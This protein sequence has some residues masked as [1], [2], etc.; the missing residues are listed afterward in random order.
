[1]LGRFVQEQKD[2]TI[3]QPH[4][5]VVLVTWMNGEP[6]PH[7]TTQQNATLLLAEKTNCKADKKHHIFCLVFS[8]QSET[9]HMTNKRKKFGGMF[10]GTK[11]VVT[12]IA[13][14]AN[15]LHW[16]GMDSI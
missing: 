8:P 4:C 2:Q 12:L 11:R 16:H 15:S 9:I 14:T 10:T 6:K 1:M 13:C 3:L 5:D 7:A